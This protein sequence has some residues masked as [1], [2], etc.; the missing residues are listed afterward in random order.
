[1][2]ALPLFLAQSSSDEAHAEP[3]PFVSDWN[4]TTGLLPDDASPAWTLFDGAEP[5]QPSLAD[6]VLT[7]ETSDDLE[8]IYYIQTEPLL[9]VTLPFVLETR[10]RFASGSS[11][12][13]T[14][15]TGFIAFT[16]VP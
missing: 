16:T 7:I 5:E 3:A 8:N 1:M 11:T 6:G 13:A 14:R 10:M 2:L 9:D 12:A 4:A 15:A